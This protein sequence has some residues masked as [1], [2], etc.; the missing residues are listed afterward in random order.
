[1]RRDRLPLA[2]FAFAGLRRSELLGLDWDDADLDRRLLRV[3]RAKGG[4]R[5]TIPIH[6]ALEPLF[7]DYLVSRAHD[8]ERALFTGV[9]VERLSTTILATTFRRYADAA[10]VTARKRV[11]PHTLRHLLASELLRAGAHLRQIQERLGHKHLDSTQRYTRITAYELCGAGKRPRFPDHG[12][13]QRRVRMAMN[14][15]DA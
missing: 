7:T 10:G 1:M 2:L 14:E 6:P 13:S 9:Q 4:R 15:R 8:L 12:M 11:T 5:R 3:R